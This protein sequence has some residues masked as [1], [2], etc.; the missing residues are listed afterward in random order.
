MLTLSN[1]GQR[2]S[3]KRHRKECWVDVKQTIDLQTGP[4]TMYAS[5]SVVN[6]KMGI[7]KIKHVSSRPRYGIVEVHDSVDSDFC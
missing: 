1:G 7:F 5:C 4:L 6:M 2:L 3:G